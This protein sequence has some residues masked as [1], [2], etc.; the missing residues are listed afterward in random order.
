MY[1]Y[2]KSIITLNADFTICG[3]GIGKSVTYM[4]QILERAMLTLFLHKYTFIIIRVNI[5]LLF[6]VKDCYVK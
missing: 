6:L 1:Y 3:H 5:Y 4:E 2:I